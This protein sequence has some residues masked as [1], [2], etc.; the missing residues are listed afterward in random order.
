MLPDWKLWE[1]SKLCEEISEKFVKLG[2][3]NLDLIP[4]RN[5]VPLE[6]DSDFTYPQLQSFY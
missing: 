6:F 5:Y 3:L 4:C 2:K 1:G